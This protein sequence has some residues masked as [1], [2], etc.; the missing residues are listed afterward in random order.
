MRPTKKLTPRKMDIVITRVTPKSVVYELFIGKRQERWWI[1]P[2]TSFDVS[3]LEIGK[4]YIV[5]SEGKFC[6]WVNY[7]TQQTEYVERYDWISAREPVDKKKLH[8]MTAK[9]REA[10]E[11]LPPIANN[12]LFTW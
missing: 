2:E 4:R 9:Q 8:C 5:E 12:D 7:Q 1:H 6:D 10:R 3:S 11:N